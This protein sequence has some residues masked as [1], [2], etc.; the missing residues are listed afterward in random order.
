MDDRSKVVEQ[1]HKACSYNILAENDNKWHDLEETRDVLCTSVSKGFINI[2]EEKNEFN[3]RRMCTIDTADLSGTERLCELPKVQQVNTSSSDNTNFSSEQ[4]SV[5]DFNDDM[6]G[7]RYFSSNEQNE[8]NESN[9]STCDSSGA[10]GTNE[11]DGSNGTNDTNDTIYLNNSSSLSFGTQFHDRG[12]VRVI[13]DAKTLATT[14]VRPENILTLQKFTC[15]AASMNSVFDANSSNGI[16][17]GKANTRSC[18]GISKNSMY[19]I[20]NSRNNFKNRNRYSSNMVLKNANNFPRTSTSRR[21]NSFK[22][23]PN[24]RYINNYINIYNLCGKYPINSTYY[25]HSFCLN[26]YE[27]NICNFYI[28]RTRYFPNN[29]GNI[30]QRVLYPIP[31]YNGALTNFRGYNTYVMYPPMQPFNLYYYRLPLLQ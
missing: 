27:E 24:Y 14:K 19:R 5:I 12:A 6:D 30:Y 21:P 25:N 7:D 4:D 17:D 23:I 9:E 11:T 31:K 3:L 15:Y 8:P 10:N 28:N 16:Y 22:R 29:I 1:G 18:S 20:S 13:P 26:N 2:E